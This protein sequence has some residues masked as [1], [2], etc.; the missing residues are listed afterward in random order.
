MARVLQPETLVHWK[1]QHLET[2]MEYLSWGEF[3]EL[4]EVYVYL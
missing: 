4:L 2:R 3:R 1:P